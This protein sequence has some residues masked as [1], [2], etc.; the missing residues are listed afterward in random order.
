MWG[1]RDYRGRRWACGREQAAAVV[2]GLVDGGPRRASGWGAGRGR[3]RGAAA[4]GGVVRARG[5]GGT[6][7][8]VARLFGRDRRKRL[9]GVG[10][11]E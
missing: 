10:Y 3:A 7:A 8:W 2:G 6:T 4:T 1:G 9:P 11:F 5:A